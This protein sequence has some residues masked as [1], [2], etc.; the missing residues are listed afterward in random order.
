ME[1]EAYDAETERNV[2]Y[3]K[4]VCAWHEKYF[5]AQKVIREAMPGWEKA[6]VSHGICG[7]CRAKLLASPEAA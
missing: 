5:G 6:G 4:T 1:T 7:E 3:L 2:K